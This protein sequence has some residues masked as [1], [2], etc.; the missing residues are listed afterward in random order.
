MTKKRNENRV[1][2]PNSSEVKKLH[3]LHSSNSNY[4]S[5]SCGGYT[6]QQ[7]HGF[8][9]YKIRIKESKK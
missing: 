3:N 1:E 2:N 9:K 6:L 4:G 7:I 5:S 8:Q